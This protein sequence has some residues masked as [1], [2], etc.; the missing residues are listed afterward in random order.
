MFYPCKIVQQKSGKNLNNFMSTN[1]V[2]FE[3]FLTLFKYDKK[4]DIYV[5]G[6]YRYTNTEVVAL[7]HIILTDNPSYNCFKKVMQF[8]NGAKI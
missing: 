2:K 4:T 6:D 1:K 7:Y 8:V 5:T 3:E